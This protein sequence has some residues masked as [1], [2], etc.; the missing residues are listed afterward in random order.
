MQT[1][2]NAEICN[3]NADVYFVKKTVLRN[4]DVATWR[5]KYLPSLEVKKY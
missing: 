3:F 1:R 4:G 2:N 5:Y